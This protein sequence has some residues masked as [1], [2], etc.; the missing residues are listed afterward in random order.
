MVIYNQIV[1]DIFNN[2]F[3][4]K[5]SKPFVVL[6]DSKITYGELKTRVKKY[7]T[8]FLG[9]GIKAGDRVVFSSKDEHFVCVFYISLL[10]NGITVVFIDPEGGSGRANAIINHC[11]SKYIF[12]DIAIQQEWNLTNL[13]NRIITQIHPVESKGYLLQKL[14]GKEKKSMQLFPACVDALLESDIAHE[15]DPEADAY[16]LFTS[17]T[18]SAPKGVRISY[19]ALFSHLDT[20]SCVYQ[21]D[22]NSKLFNNLILTHTDGI[23]QGLLLT[24]FNSA[25]VF[26]PFPFSIQRIEDI[27]DIVYRENI[28]HW[29]MVPTMIG[30]IYQFK[31]NDSDS[32]YNNHFKY[33]ISCGAK[34]ENLLW[35]KFEEKFKTLIINGYG[36]TE[37]V[38]GGLFAGP[39]TASHII[40]TIGKPVDCD[41]KIMGENQQE[42]II[43]EEGE[44]W[45][46]GSL[47][48][49]GYLNAPDANREA[50]YRE[51]FKTGDIGFIG[52]DGCF[53]ITGRKKLMIITGGIN[54]FPEEVTE[55]LHS[56]SAIQ[57]AVTFGLEDNT[58]GE[59]VA[60]AIVVKKQESLSKDEIIT[61]CRK[62]LEE[63]KV[64]AKVFFVDELPYG[65]SGKVIINDIKKIAI[66][67]IE[68][69][70]F[71]AEIEPIFLNIVS[72]SFHLPIENISLDMVA[73][74]TS[75]WDSISHIMMIAAMEKYFDIEFAALEVMN[76]RILSDLYSMIERKKKK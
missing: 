71:S 32:L 48:M 31:Q 70:L 28:T 11:E 68:P 1:K 55:V 30:L 64:P 51:W 9:N 74:E 17:G 58:W 34:L 47:L 60:C 22:Y 37:T 12:V 4:Q 56:H 50:F 73:E 27:F 10:A 25:T 63:S 39:D 49:S 36:L 59:I 54:V 20:L 7:S 42:K 35:Q 46:R 67:N 76:V 24:L 45:I 19:R 15:I 57:D 13:D 16:I 21:I 3:K 5:G 6:R 72:Q 65:R 53:R 69:K 75:E 43:G 38:T 66:E 33:V 62:H 29:V 18:T 8:F 40:G 2:A 14:L 52:K 26:R 61:Y 44:I 23:I 41:A